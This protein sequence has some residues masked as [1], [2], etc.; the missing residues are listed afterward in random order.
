MIAVDMVVLRFLIRFSPGLEPAIGILPL[1]VRVWVG[2]RQ[3]VIPAGAEEAAA[4]RERSGDADG[5]DSA[6][7]AC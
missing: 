2:A 7:A 5:L 1:P 4:V 6:P 3:A